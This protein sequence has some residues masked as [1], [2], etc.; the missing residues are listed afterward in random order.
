MTIRWSNSFE[1]ARQRATA[2][3]KPLYVDFFSPT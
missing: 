1:E 3:Q 2:E